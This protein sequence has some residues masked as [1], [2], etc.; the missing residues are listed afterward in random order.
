MIVLFLL[1]MILA[2]P[3]RCWS[4]SLVSIEVGA[5]ANTADSRTQHI[6][7]SSAHSRA[8][9]KKAYSLRVSS[10]N[11][12]GRW[13]GPVELPIK[14]GDVLTPAKIFDSMEAL[15]STI[16]D[17]TIN[18]YGLRSKGEI[19]VLYIEVDYD[20]SQS[21]TASEASRKTVGVTFRPHYVQ[22]SLMNIGDNVLPIPRSALPTFYNNVP[23]AL[24]DLKPTMGIL[25]DRSFGAALG[26]SFET[27]LLNLSD[28]GHISNSSGEN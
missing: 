10:V 19:G 5:D 15:E 7:Y 16:T 17:N 22:F 2:C 27:D 3:V 28:P 12:E 9:K 25:Y 4:V 8:N 6:N 1:F 14:V 21:S 18:G 24:L 23:V 13:K 11:V 20:T 26:F